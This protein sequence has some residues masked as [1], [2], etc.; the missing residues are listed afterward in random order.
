[1]YSKIKTKYCGEYLKLASSKPCNLCENEI[2][3]GE[4]IANILAW[5]GTEPGADLLQQKCWYVTP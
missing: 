2:V 5:V 1:M 3:K 4:K